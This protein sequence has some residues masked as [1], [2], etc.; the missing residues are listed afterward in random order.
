[1]DALGFEK[2]YVEI[3][4]PW[5]CHFFCIGRAIKFE[6]NYLC[7]TLFYY[8]FLFVLQRY[9]SAHG[10]PAAMQFGQNVLSEMCNN[11]ITFDVDNVIRCTFHYFSAYGWPT[12]TKTR[13]A[14]KPVNTCV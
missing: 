5:Y 13:P 8:F 1:M 3:L 10:W 4:I 14:G 9:F 7:A 2:H 12:I 11:S 6:H